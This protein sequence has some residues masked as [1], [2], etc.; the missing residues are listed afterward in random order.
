MKRY[1][2]MKK[3]GIKSARVHV[4]GDYWL[5]GSVLRG[6]VTSGWSGVRTHFEVDSDEPASKLISLIK[7][8]K[9]GCFAERLVD[10]AIPLTSA[11]TLNGV[12]VD[13][14]FPEGS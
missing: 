14:G 2:S 12:G 1:A 13:V 10:T 6:D 8:A 5:T 7:L 4:E 11:I 9:A 3:L